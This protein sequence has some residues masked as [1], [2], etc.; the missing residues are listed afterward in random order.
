[1]GNIA[2]PVIH[3]IN[4]N[5][6]FGQ[7]QPKIVVTVGGFENTVHVR[8]RQIQ[9]RRYRYCVGRLITMKPE[10][11]ATGIHVLPFSLGHLA[12]RR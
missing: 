9:Q 12:L 1:M 7:I 5:T 4:L 11:L 3:R 8:T 6:P 10:R 2:G